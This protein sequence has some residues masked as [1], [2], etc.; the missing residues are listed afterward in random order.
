MEARDD[1]GKQT[2]V[3]VCVMMKGNACVLCV[4]VQ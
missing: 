1:D 2:H 3:A 4:L